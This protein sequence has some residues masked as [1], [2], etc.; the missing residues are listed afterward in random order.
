MSTQDRQDN[1]TKQIVKLIPMWIPI[2]IGNLIPLYGV[3]F[4]GWDI[5]AI[6]FLYWIENIII[7]FFT[8]VKILCIGASGFLK[9]GGGEKITRIIGVPFS[10]GFFTFHYGM[11]CMGHLTFIKSFFYEG[12]FEGGV[13]GPSET[14]SFTLNVAQDGLIYGILAVFIIE[15]LRTSKDLL[16]PNQA[17][18]I[19]PE[20]SKRL[21]NRKNSHLSQEATDK[22][23]LIQLAMFAPYGRIIVLHL[24]IIF[25]GILAEKLGTPLW[26]LG[27]LIVLKIAY[28]LGLIH[29]IRKTK[30]KKKVR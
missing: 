23:A 9:A 17:N 4:W 30:H 29:P 12:T 11:F 28:D 22:F 7:G 27:L 16:S 26:T 19:F 21:R 24:T 13:F 3:L 1:S 10:I 18:G 2:V 20:L 6:F 8:V 5:F 14:F 15:L 25:G